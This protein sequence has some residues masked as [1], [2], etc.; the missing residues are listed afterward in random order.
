MAKEEPQQQPEVDSGDSSD[1]LIL[2]ND[3]EH[4]DANTKQH[5][6]NKVSEGNSKKGVPSYFRIDDLGALNSKASRNA[7]NT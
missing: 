3:V 5:N 4:D 1:L 2:D 6:Q 7:Q